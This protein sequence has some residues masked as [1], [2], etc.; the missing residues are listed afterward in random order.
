MQ[1][2]NATTPTNKKHHFGLLL[3]RDLHLHHFFNR[4]N[5][6]HFSPPVAN[7][8]ISPLA[9]ETV[10]PAEAELSRALNQLSSVTRLFN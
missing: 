8:T 6:Q 2:K 1:L 7:K 5:P 4:Q 9:S 3:R 10:S